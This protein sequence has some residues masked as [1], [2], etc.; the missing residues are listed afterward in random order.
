M[1]AYGTLTIPTALYPGD[2]SL[3]FNAEAVTAPK[4]GERVALGKPYNTGIVYVGVE[5]HF[6]GAPGAFEVDLQEADTDTANAYQLV[7][8]ISA[9]DSNNYARGD[10]QVTGLFC[11][12]YVKT[13]TNAVNVTVKLTQR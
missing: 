12:P 8:S 13:L 11:R 10:F 5:L 3:S 7:G 9:V 2:S 4:A 1:P 6:S